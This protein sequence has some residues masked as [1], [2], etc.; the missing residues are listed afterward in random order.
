MAAA[1]AFVF[2]AAVGSGMSSK[3]LA[4]GAYVENNNSILRTID[5][6]YFSN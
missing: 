1:G 6:E 3:L 4:A 2:A 5:E